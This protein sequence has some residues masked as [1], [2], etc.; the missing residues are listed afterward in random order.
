[1]RK[2]YLDNLRS[3]TIILVMI[4][5]AFYVFN[6]VGLPTGLNVE[7]GFLPFDAFCTAVYP[8]FMVLLFCIAGITAR[9][10]I[11]KRG[12]KLFIQ[13][14]F[15]KLIIPSTLGLLVF[16]WITGYF[17]I[18]VGGGLDEMPK[19]FSSSQMLPLYSCGIFFRP[20]FHM[21]TYHKD[22]F[23]PPRYL[24]LAQE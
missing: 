5:H 13:E 19:F 11:N 18:L 23:L 8:W 9:Y 14:R 16:Q 24:P 15:R 1:M 22:L 7:V 3:L 4:Y 20:L 21:D 10:S 6:G 17:N 2:Y 12:R